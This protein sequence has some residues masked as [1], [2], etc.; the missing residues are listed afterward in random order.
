MVRFPKVLLGLFVAVGVTIAGCNGATDI[1]E[2]PP[3]DVESP[4]EETVDD[5]KTTA[6]DPKATADTPTV[7][8]QAND[9]A[10]ATDT[11][12]EM[13]AVSIYVMDDSCSNFKAESVEVPAA[14]PMSG[15]VGEVLE[16]HEFEAFK[17]SG[18]RVK[19]ENSKATVD[20]R[21]A[22]DSERQF[23]S[24]SSCEQQGLFG[25]LEETLMQNPSWQV[26]QVEFTNRGKEIVL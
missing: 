14:E 11:K 13:V 17:L 24:L 3:A 25:G 5:E 8:S 1:T 16:R 18:Y 2:P 12:P 7:E 21:L 20:L 19:V 26:D 4:A 10:P 9:T 15:A 22:E 23:L 6:D